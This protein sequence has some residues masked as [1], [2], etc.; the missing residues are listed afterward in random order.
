M[1]KYVLVAIATAIGM[2]GLGYFLAAVV[3]D[4]ILGVKG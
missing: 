3:F 1:A 4:R 2:V